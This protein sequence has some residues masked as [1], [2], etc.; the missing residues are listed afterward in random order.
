M[1]R[2]PSGGGG[3]GHMA[4]GEAAALKVVFL[5]V[6]GVICCNKYG[7]LEEEKLQNLRLVVERSGASIVLST[8]W[9]RS[10][11]HKRK[12]CRVLEDLG[13]R[14]IG[15]TMQ[16]P[17]MHP[18]RPREIIGWLEGYEAE[19]R[20]HSSPAVLSWV[21]VDDRQLLCEEMGD[22]LVRVRSPAR[23]GHLPCTCP[24]PPAQA[25]E[26]GVES[27]CDA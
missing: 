23:S 10:P 20:R 6:D 12:L 3:S 15:A 1:R 14:V 11:T 4:S 2:P 26:R 5:D 7:H 21:A 18:V 9:R 24:P 8:D 17:T 22:R 16:G 25:I 13:M 27:V 19:R